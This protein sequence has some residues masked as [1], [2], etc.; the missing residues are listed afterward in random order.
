[1]M[2]GMITLILIGLLRGIIEAFP[3]ESAPRSLLRD[4]DAIYGE[5]FVRRVQ[6][7]GIPEVLTR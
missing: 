2:A 1:M 6:G 7:I 4:R 5:A 3:D